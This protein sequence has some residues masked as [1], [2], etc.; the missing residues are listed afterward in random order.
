MELLKPPYHWEQIEPH[1]TWRSRDHEY[2]TQQ[3]QEVPY[4]SF[5]NIDLGAPRGKQLSPSP[6]IS[7]QAY[8]TSAES[9]HGC[10]PQLSVRQRNQRP[11]K[12][13]TP[14]E[15]SVHLGEMN[16]PRMLA[17]SGSTSNLIARHPDFDEYQPGS[18]P[19]TW[20]ANRYQGTNHAM[21]MAPIWDAPEGRSADD[22]DTRSPY[23]P[24]N[25]VSSAGLDYEHNV[26]GCLPNSPQKSAQVPLCHPGNSSRSEE[27]QNSN[28][29]RS[30][31]SC[32]ADENQG[33]T[34]R[35]IAKLES[36]RSTGVELD[37]HGENSAVS[38][39]KTSIGW[40]S[41][42]RRV[43]YGYTLVPPEHT[44]ESNLPRSCESARDSPKGSKI[45]EHELPD[46]QATQQ[47]RKTSKGVSKTS[48]SSFDISA[49][50]QRLNLP[51]WTGASFALRTSNN[52]D[53]GSCESG[54]SS[55]FG[56]LPNK[57]KTHEQ[58]EPHA[59]AENPWEFCS[60]V[61]PSQSLGEQQAAQRDRIRSHEHAEVQ[62]ID[63][64]ATLRRR[65]GAWATKRKISEI[66]RNIE[67]RAVAKIAASTE[68]F[69]VVQRTATRVLRLKAPGGKD[70]LDKTHDDKPTF[71]AS[72]V[73]GNEDLGD[74]AAAPR[75]QMSSTS[76][77]D[78][79]SLYEECLEERT[80]PE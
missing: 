79:D 44:S 76:S 39:R 41:E 20:T 35:F 33:L 38:P 30:Q 5:Y 52:S 50:L 69:P 10:P 68:Q 77:G 42:G 37:S 47:T 2:R 11:R 17:S 7:K 8:T 12:E 36:D 55:L 16:I 70:P 56:I 64:L 66:A 3:F 34:N 26:L 40:L 25:S 78:W 54:G 49:I 60:W 73:D 48:E 32:I 23:S 9:L 43:G 67:R 27:T 4:T 31:E 1:Q 15:Q 21:V 19:G 29:A 13:M 65:G 18:N 75:R 58:L 6:S 14:D 59:E 24:K 71:S 80:I 46:R 57:R 72:Q 22:Q 74:T 28:P 63:K 61:P 53:V 62:L 51:R 45:T